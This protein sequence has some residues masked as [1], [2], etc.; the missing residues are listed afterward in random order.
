M[1]TLSIDS[2]LYFIYEDPDSEELYAYYFKKFTGTGATSF[3]ISNLVC[4]YVGDHTKYFTNFKNSN[5]CTIFF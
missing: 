5:I 4:K 3:D 2:D 1:C